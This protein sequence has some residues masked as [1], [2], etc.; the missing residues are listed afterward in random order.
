MVYVMSLYSVDY[1]TEKWGYG[2]SSSAF[3]I[4]LLRCIYA[5][6]IMYVDLTSAGRYSSIM[7][8]AG[9]IVSPFVGWIIGRY[10]SSLLLSIGFCFVVF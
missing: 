3:L 9:L 5:Y 8:V 1:L 10:C 4:V 6:R 2:P 7:Y